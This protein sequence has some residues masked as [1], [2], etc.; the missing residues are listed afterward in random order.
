[1]KR[2]LSA[3]I[4]IGSLAGSCHASDKA[5]YKLPVFGKTMV[6]P[7][8][9]PLKTFLKDFVSS[10]LSNKNLQDK[11]NKL[12]KKF[13]NKNLVK[14]TPAFR[15]GLWAMATLAIHPQFLKTWGF[16]AIIIKYTSEDL[17]DIS[18]IMQSVFGILDKKKSYQ[19]PNGL[20]AVYKQVGIK[21][22]KFEK[23]LDKLFNMLFLNIKSNIK[24]K[25]LIQHVQDYVLAV[26]ILRNV[27]EKLL[28]LVE[29][30]VQS[31]FFI[32]KVLLPYESMRISALEPWEDKKTK[33]S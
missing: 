31:K 27:F 30:T 21:G 23:E 18:A 1:M 13:K 3:L 10:F 20:S 26:N 12:H 22:K 33:S 2:F 15:P 24:E 19:V 5:F 16:L 14:P 9:K 7:I 25:N 4:L 11:I 28:P 17:G 6:Y 29:T 32:H 8:T